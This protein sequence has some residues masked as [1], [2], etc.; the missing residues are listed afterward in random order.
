MDHEM[1]RSLHGGKGRRPT[2][3]YRLALKAMTEIAAGTWQ[4]EFGKP[5]G[6]QYNAGQHVRM[7]LPS[8]STSASGGNSRFLSFASSP[9]EA[10][11]AFAVRMRE[12]PFKMALLSLRPGDEVVVEMLAK[13]PPAAFGSD[14]DSADCRLFVA[15]GIGIVPAYSMIKAI[16]HKTPDCDLILIALNRTPNDAPYLEDLRSMSRTQSGL[17]FVPV[18][19]QA[20]EWNGETG[21]LSRRKLDQLVPRLKERRVYVT[22]LEGMVRATVQMLRRAGVRRSHI[23]SEQFG[24]FSMGNNMHKK[25]AGR[26]ALLLVIVLAIIGLHLAG[27]VYVFR[28]ALSSLSLDV[29]FLTGIGLAAAAIVLL[30]F[31]AFRWFGTRHR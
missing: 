13:V 5:D 17:S 10:D 19:T 16:L 11:L 2:I 24:A 8:V 22:G 18:M 14:I 25:H 6:F 7:T 3:A 20:T 15:G 29:S 27:G 21:R 26:S 12:T 4:F 23:A 28:T 31:L 30:K 9:H 1:M